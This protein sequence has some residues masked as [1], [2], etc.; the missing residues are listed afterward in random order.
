MFMCV[1]AYTLKEEINRKRKGQVC[2]KQ[3][4]NNKTE[5]QNTAL[6]LLIAK[7]KR[8]RDVSSNLRIVSNMIYE[9]LPPLY[10][11]PPGLLWALIIPTWSHLTPAPSAWNSGL[12]KGLSKVGEKETKS[13]NPF[14]GSCP[15]PPFTACMI[16]GIQVTFPFKQALS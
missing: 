9:S 2:Q 11:F 8:I 12:S 4:K 3:S 7:G 5:G 14:H 6:S 13:P 15:P 1:C 10:H 16:S